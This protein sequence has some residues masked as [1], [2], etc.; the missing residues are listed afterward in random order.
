MRPE[1]SGVT[2]PERDAIYT[3]AARQAAQAAEHIR[4]CA[5][6]DPGGAAD[7][8]WA[9]ADTLHVAARALRNPA[10]RRAA[11]SFSRAARAPHGRI[12]SR[13]YDGDGL[14][15]TARLL[16]LTGAAGDGTLLVA[17]LVSLVVAVME[18]RQAQ[19]HTAQ[20]SA[21]AR[22]AAHL[23]KAVAEPRSS[24]ARSAKPSHPKPAPARNAADF[25]RQDCAAPLNLAAMPPTHPSSTSSHARSVRRPRRRA[26]PSP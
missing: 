24:T 25:A 21:A 26:G 12:P 7:A 4:R 10:L 13:T 11:D 14:R 2:A 22:A 1:R 5:Y 3:H 15:A 8:A 9:A 20:A 6:T 16:A 23:C 18:L 19:L 17:N